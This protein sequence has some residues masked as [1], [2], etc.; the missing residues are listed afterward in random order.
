VGSGDLRVQKPAK[1]V[2]GGGGAR[3]FRAVNI[4]VISAHPDD[5]VLGVGGT[6]VRHAEQGDLVYPV[7][8]ADGSQVRY[9]EAERTRLLDACRLSCAILG[10]E[11]PEFVGLPDQRLDG[12]PQIEL[13]QAI[14]RVLAARKPSIVYTHHFGDVNRDHQTLH[15]AT[16]V[17][18]RPKP[19]AQV[20][21]VLAFSAPSSTEWAPQTMQRVFAPNWFVDITP[22]IKKKIQALA[23]YQSETP[24][25]PHP[26]SL[27]AIENHAKFYG[28]A[29]G[30][31]YAEPFVLMRNLVDA[32][33]A[34]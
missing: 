29:V 14:E 1:F 7:I 31:A 15:D 13:T 8:F 21:R 22:T 28:C 34:L 12:M 27:E 4:V 2:D 26:R 19:G 20:R 18:T 17:A 25:Y 24:A 30:F 32:S 9:D 3:D 11:P 6:L 5:E 23:C 16:M 10:I 33:G